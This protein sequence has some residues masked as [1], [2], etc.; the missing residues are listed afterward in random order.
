MPVQQDKALL[1]VAEELWLGLGEEGKE[2]GQQ[3]EEVDTHAPNVG[4]IGIG[5]V[6]H[7]LRGH[8]KGRATVSI[9][10]L[11][12]KPKLFGETEVGNLNNKLLLM[13]KFDH[14][15]FALNAGHSWVKLKLSLQVWEM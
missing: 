4:L 11:I 10:L 1:D 8:A 13:K 12:N 14:T 15:L 3:T 9:D 7:D 2:P 6:V 5:L